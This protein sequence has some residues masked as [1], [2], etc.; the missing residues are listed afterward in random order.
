VVLAGGELDPDVD[1]GDLAFPVA[2][3]DHLDQPEHRVVRCA[4]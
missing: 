2:A 1:G 3:D 4:G